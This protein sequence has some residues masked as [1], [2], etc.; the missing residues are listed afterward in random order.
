MGMI[1]YVCFYEL[2]LGNFEKW[3]HDRPE[4]IFMDVINSGVPH[5]AQRILKILTYLE[6]FIVSPVSENLIN[7]VINSFRDVQ[8]LHVFRGA[9]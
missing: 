9:V 1:L 6:C 5:H 4:G 8:N 7:G 3:N 2:R